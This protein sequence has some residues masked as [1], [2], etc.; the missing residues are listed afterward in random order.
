MDVPHV[1]IHVVPKSLVLHIHLMD[2]IL[3]T[4]LGMLFHPG[5]LFLKEMSSYKNGSILSR[6]PRHG[7]VSFR[8]SLLLIQSS[9]RLVSVSTFQLVISIM[10]VTRNN[11]T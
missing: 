5:C 9:Y 2:V 3:Q 1:L 4:V 7:N 8:F 10:S 11:E 6:G